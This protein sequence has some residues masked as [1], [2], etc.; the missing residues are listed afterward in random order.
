LGWPPG[1]VT[2]LLQRY[3]RQR[4]PRLLEMKE[5]LD[6]GEKLDDYDIDFL[7]M[8]ADERKDRNQ[9]LQTAYRHPELHE[10]VLKAID[11]YHEI[12]SKAL[13]NER[14]G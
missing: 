7:Q 9:A 10:L 14:G 8:I 11:L 1:L 13:E 4:L 12:T 2:T 5:R 3:T 6:R